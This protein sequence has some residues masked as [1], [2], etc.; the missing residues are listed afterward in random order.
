MK[1][2]AYP[3]VSERVS[4]LWV[5]KDGIGA[6][7]RREPRRSEIVTFGKSPEVVV[8]IAREANIGK[9]FV[10]HMHTLDESANEIRSAYKSLGYRPMLSEEFFVHDMK[11]IPELD[12]KPAI[13]RV[14][15]LED[16]DKIKRN[17]RNRKPIRD[18]DL[19]AENPEHRLH[20]VIE[21]NR[22]YG[23]VGSVPFGKDTWISDLF[24]RE[25]YRGKGF[26]RALM[27]KVM[28]EDK[29]FGIERSVLLASGAGA[30]LYPHMGYEHIG[31]LQLFCPKK[32]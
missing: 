19:T 2:F 29:K 1:A 6:K 28:Q 18:A 20:A 9:H 11:N 25:E 32:S 15:S 10:S 31:S 22:A 3:Y 26:G 30:R 17:R 13:S 7:P 5:M 4:G 27:S 23:W 8:E 21:R 14:V 24:V 16:S 12:S